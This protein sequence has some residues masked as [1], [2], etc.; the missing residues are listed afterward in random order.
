MCHALRSLKKARSYGRFCELEVEMFHHKKSMKQFN[1][2]PFRGSGLFIVN[3]Y[4]ANNP[5]N[6]N[7]C[8]NL[9]WLVTKKWE[10]RLRTAL[11][12]SLRVRPM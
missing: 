3:P 12:R 4:K 9:R 5:K 2:D 8:L 10:L 11:S 7:Y 6:D 1:V